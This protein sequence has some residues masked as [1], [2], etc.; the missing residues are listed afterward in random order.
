[1]CDFD[2]FKKAALGWAL[3]TYIAELPLRVCRLNASEN[4]H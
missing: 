4:L 3:P 1:M 2:H